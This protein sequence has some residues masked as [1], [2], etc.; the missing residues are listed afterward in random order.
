VSASPADPRQVISSHQGFR[1]SL[2][3]F[4]IGL[5]L[6]ACATGPKQ[7]PKSQ[8]QVREMQT[9]TYDVRD[10]KLVMKAMLNVLQDDDF[11]VR[12]ANSELGFINATKDVDL[13]NRG[14]EFFFHFNGIGLAQPAVDRNAVIDCTANVSEFGKGVRVRINFQSKVMDS[15][16]AVSNVQTIQEDKYYQDFFSKVDKGIFLQKEKL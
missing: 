6:S 1:T 13:G 8:L 4:S 9:R 16:G 11:I 2:T 10:M 3:A 7:P 5:I 15:R 12:Q 14:G